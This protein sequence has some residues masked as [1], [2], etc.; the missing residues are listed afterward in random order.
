MALTSGGS[1]IRDKRV[2]LLGAKTPN[3]G[4]D[5]AGARKIG[6]GIDAASILSREAAA[7]AAL[8]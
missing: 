6:H 5:S 7:D 3:G 2:F 1:N 8:C 4:A